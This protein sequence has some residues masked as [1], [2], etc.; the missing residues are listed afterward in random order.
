M[1]PT[2]KTLVLITATLLFCA[3]LAHG[4]DTAPIGFASIN[5][6]GQNGTTGG[7][8]GP[9][10]TV[11]TADELD[12]YAN[13]NTPYII[14]IAGNISLYS[15]NIRDDKT[16]VGIGPNAIVSGMLTVD[17]H[18]NIIIRNLNLHGS[19]YNALKITDGSH[20]VW[21]DHCDLMDA[22]DDL[23]EIIKGSDDVT[24]SWCRFHYSSPHE[25]VLAMWI[26]SDDGRTS[27]R[28]KLHV[29]LHH[30]W[31]AENI[32]ERMP[33]A[34]Y[35]N[36]HIFNDY[37]TS[38]GNNFCVRARVAAQILVQNSYFAHV[39]NPLVILHGDAETR[40]N[41]PSGSIQSQDNVFEQ[42]TGSQD[43]SGVVF[44][45]PYAWTPDKASDVPTLVPAGAGPQAYNAEKPTEVATDD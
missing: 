37:F 38:S 27:D 19:Q 35:G 8:G 23:V 18:K 20:H 12:H 43:A 1:K 34:R 30:N 21:L 5:D 16:L 41:L 2:P 11:T 42:T 10:V 32:A 39:N 45:P 29:T 15:L 26:G 31:W 36:V 9:I 44:T 3:N 22:N 7:A 6:L 14:Q 4:L 13:Q 17:H 28:G 40:L 33:G 25:H 24:V